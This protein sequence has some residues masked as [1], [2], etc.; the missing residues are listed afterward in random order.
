ME[1]GA[2]TA[3]ARYHMT[4]KELVDPYDKLEVGALYVHELDG[5]DA[6]F[7]VLAM[8]QKGTAVAGECEY[9]LLWTNG[10]T[11][12]WRTLLGSRRSVRLWKVLPV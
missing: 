6:A 5:N 9:L 11:S 3:K 4:R 2:V 8:N 10:K 12:T 7:V 1:T